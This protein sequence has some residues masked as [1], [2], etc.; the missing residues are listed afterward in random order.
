MY[1]FIHLCKIKLLIKSNNMKK[2]IYP[3]LKLW[4]FLFNLLLVKTA[5]TQCTEYVINGSFETF[6]PTPPANSTPGY[7]YVPYATGW[8]N[9]GAVT[10]TPDLF[11]TSSPS[12]PSYGSSVNV[13]CNFAGYQN[14]HTGNAYAGLLT[15]QPDATPSHNPYNHEFIKNTLAS[16]LVSGKIYEVSLWVSRADLSRHELSSLGIWLTD[17]PGNASPDLNCPVASINNDAWTKISFPYCATGI[18]N[19]I[20]IGGSSPV[21]GNTLTVGG[22]ICTPGNN[23]PNMYGDDYVYIDD[24]SIKEIKFSVPTQTLCAKQ[25]GT[26]SAIPTCSTITMSALTYTWNYGDGSATVSTNTLNVTTHSY[27]A[28]PNG[29]Y[30]ATLSVGNGT[31]VNSYT[32]SVIVPKVSTSISSGTANTICNGS[33]CFTATPTPI[34]TYTA[35]WTLTDATTHSVIPSNS[36]TVTNNTSLYPCIN[37][38]AINQNVY[39]CV[40]LTNTLGCTFKDSLFMPSCC[41][42]PTN[43]VKHANKTFTVN[44]AVSTASV[45]FG[46]TITVNNNITLT[47]L[48][49]NA[50]LDPNTKFVLNGNAKVRFVN[51]YVHGCNYMWDGIYPI[52]TGTV[53][54]LNSIVEDAKRVAVDSLGG[55]TI[56]VTN[57]Y[58][59]KNNMGIAL[60]ANKTSTS[61]VTVKNVLFT[62]SNVSIPAGANKTPAVQANLTNAATLGAFT[63]T[64]M[65]PPYNTQ[66]S[67]CGVYV[68]NA[69][70]TGKTNSA[71]V[72]GTITNEEN[73]FD[74]MQMGIFSYDSK[75]QVQNNV[76]Q[77]IKNTIAPAGFTNTGIYILGPIFGAGNGSYL[78]AGGSIAL[79]NTF[80]SNDYGI[81]DNGKSA[82]LATYNTFSVQTTGTYVTGNNNGSIVSINFN[83]FY[84][85]GIAVNFFNNTYLTGNIKNNNMNNTASAVGTYADNFAIRCTEATLATNPNSYPAFDID[86]NN[87]SGYYNGIYA[88]NT[89]S[90][91]AT[92]NEVHMRQDNA[93]DHWQ[94]GICVTGSNANK[95]INNIVDMPG[96][97]QWAYW[98]SGIFMTANQV[99]RVQ[100]NSIN[101]L[102][103]SITFKQNNSTVVGDGV[104]SNYMQN[105]QNGVWMH[106]NAIIGNQAGNTGTNSAD[107]VWATTCNLYTYTQGSS[108]PSS[109]IFFTRSLG[110]GY[111]LPIA[112][113]AN[114]GSFGC[115]SMQGN[116]SS[117]AATGTTCIANT[118][119]PSNLK[120][121][122]N[123]LTSI[124]Q[125]ADDILTDFDNEQNNSL[126]MA[127]AAANVT[128]NSAD[129]TV[130]LKAMNRRHLLYNLVLQNID[131]Q[132]DAALSGFMTGIKSNNTGLLLAVDSLIHQAE[133]SS[134]LVTVAQQANAAIVTT[135]LVEQAQQ[136]FNSIY[137]SYLAQNKKLSEAGL[138]NLE[139]LALLC[140]SYY[141]TAVYQARTVLF[142]IT[143]QS[144]RNACENVSPNTSSKRIGQTTDNITQTTDITVYPNPANT[145]V[146]IDAKN[147]DTVLLKLYDV[148][149][150]LVIEETIS[151]NEKLDVHNLSNGIYIYKLYHN[152]TELKVGKLIITH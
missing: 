139:T 2:S 9:Y 33:Y 80:L 71:I 58:I 49:T 17:V 30:T 37:F 69:S 34:G 115:F 84:Q 60:K 39:I 151:S 91:I 36:Y 120:V 70:H 147:Y 66:K 130:S 18:E 72:I 127:S 55:A 129:N 114:D 14:A 86:N 117:A 6:S 38:A 137:L 103:M 10:G 40:T 51:S 76:F 104:K 136:E 54:I 152:D 113:A 43:V 111:D 148:M 135:N 141:G 48:Q 138:S 63:S 146:F 143:K 101:N 81:Y 79:K 13:P 97:N 1:Y 121:A 42:T 35:N 123:A 47:L 74:K 3:K 32:Y 102:S 125:G 20:I 85:N 149:G 28:S 82:L 132:Q 142:D 94:S 128:D 64:V 15:V 46:G 68:A 44:T 118:A 93:N 29:N 19:S 88:V 112:K 134:S 145:I 57:S 124:M 31:C 100:C 5:F 107:N 83:N 131:V 105:A 96:L 45:S 99:P 25:V 27:A 108:N 73:V 50:Q 12:N 78:S 122:G 26:F 24:V 41:A 140:P 53:D 119:T 4:L 77:N 150:H 109:H 59:N 16:T 75:L 98:Q 133:K 126:S 92:D 110:S 23:V 89:L 22:N 61:A 116:N 21:Y 87:I 95:I 106:D 90:L 7:Q 65:L 62:C 8:T 67:F 144:Y 56:L 52:A 11:T